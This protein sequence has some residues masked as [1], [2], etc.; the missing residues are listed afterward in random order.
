MKQPNV[1]FYTQFSELNKSSIAGFRRQIHSYV[2]C[3]LNAFWWYS[4]C[5][6]DVQIYSNSNATVIWMFQANTN[7]WLVYSIFDQ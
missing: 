6:I 3:I 7:V 4:K 1:D 2:H 5:N